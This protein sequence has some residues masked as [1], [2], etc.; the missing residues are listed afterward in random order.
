MLVVLNAGIMSFVKRA[1]TTVL[2]AVAAFSLASA[3]AAAQSS[4]RTNEGCVSATGPDET[5]PASAMPPVRDGKGQPDIVLFAAVSA[6]EVT[7]AKQ[8]KIC[9][10]LRGDAQL[11]SVHVIGR[12]NLASPV[13]SNTTYRNV[14]VAV[15]ILGRLNATCIASRITR[16]PADSASRGD[17]ASLDVRTG[18]GATRPGGPP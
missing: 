10:K 3:N 8:P 9:V 14:Y 7:F 6:D 12:K 1:F 2:L 16:A 11:D 13:V 15:E 5:A 4:A 17:C 18:A